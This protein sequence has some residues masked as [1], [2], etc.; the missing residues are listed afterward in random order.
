MKRAFKLFRVDR[1]GRLHSL[2]IGKVVTLPIGQ[3]LR[4][5]SIPTKGF[6][7]RPGWHCCSEQV[8]PHL[9]IS[10]VGGMPR[11]WAVVEID[12]W[13]NEHDRPASQGGLW[14][15]AE[16][17]RIVRVIPREGIKVA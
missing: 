11:V 16:R 9:V 15:T 14:F 13:M 6:A 5:E 17:M 2:F 3:W 10:P 8:A 12:G 7:V 4:A 1:S